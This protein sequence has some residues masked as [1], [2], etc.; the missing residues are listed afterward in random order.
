MQNEITPLRLQ[1]RT[2][3]MTTYKEIASQS[4]L[5]MT[6]LSCRKCEGAVEFLVM[7]VFS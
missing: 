6:V 7:T 4:S 3:L 5:A 1:L 2:L